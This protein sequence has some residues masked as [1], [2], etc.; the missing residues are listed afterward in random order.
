MSEERMIPMQG[1]DQVNGVN[2][3]TDNSPNGTSDTCG[4]A[5]RTTRQNPRELDDARYAALD[6]RAHSDRARA[7]VSAVTDLVVAQELA[8]GTRTNKRKRKQTAL[9]SAVEGLLADLLQARISDKTKGYVYRP[10]R[11]S[12][13]T[14]GI[15]SSRVFKALV[16]ALVDLGLLEKHLGFQ[17]LDEPFGKRAAV[18]RKA[19]RFR[20]TR[21]LLDIYEKHGVR[22][23]DFHQH[24]LIPLPE[25]PLQ[26]RAASKRTEYGQKIPGKP[27]RYMRTEVTERAERSLKRLNKFFD[28]FKL[29]GGIHRGFIRV[30]NNGDHPKFA[31]NMGGRLYSYGENNYQQMEQADRL[32]MRI[33]YRSVCEID[34]RASYLTIFH[35]LCGESFDATKDPY[36]MPGLGEEGRDAVKMWITASFGNNA[37]ITKWPRELVAKYRAKTGKALGKR[38][39]ASKVGDKVMQA[40]PLLARLGEV[41]NGIERGWAELM[42]IESRAM[43]RTMIDLARESIPS[44]AVH[45]SIIVPYLEWRRATRVL[46]EHYQ[47]FA[48]ATPVLITNYQKKF[49]E[50]PPPWERDDDVVQI[51]D[52]KWLWTSRERP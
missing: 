12:S 1:E 16:D 45:D 38:Y 15:V 51:G 43:F 40:F 23:V 39:A 3:K 50:I 49:R 37:P 6:C 52:A 10:M 7:L 22:A 9:R 29:E 24:F 25:H 17:M 47:E 4:K 46:T 5:E 30:F 44:L 31:W 28:H 11:P 41:V 35:G 42:Y 27:I 32:R 2:L 21:T 18:I 14:E 34:I 36:V 13:F 33:S 19:T 8:A 48:N 20:A 26:L